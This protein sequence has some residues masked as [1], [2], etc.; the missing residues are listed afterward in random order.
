LP[1]VYPSPCLLCFVTPNK[2]D[3]SMLPSALPELIAFAVLGFLLLGFLLGPRIRLD[4]R[5]TWGSVPAVRN[6]KDLDDW[7]TTS[8]A[9]VPSLRAGTEARIEWTNP[10]QPGRTPIAFLYIHGFSASWQETAPVTSRLGQRF[11]ANVLQMRV[12]G[13]G[14]SPGDMLVDANEWLQ[15]VADAW[16]VAAQLGERIVIVATSNGAPLALWLKQQPGVAERLGALFFIAPNFRLRNPAGRMLTW[17]WA[18]V[19]AGWVAPKQI[20]WELNTDLERLV[21]TTGYSIKAVQQ[22][23]A[24]LDWVQRIRYD[25]EE[26]PLALMYVAADPTVHA[27]SAIAVFNQWGRA[28]HPPVS[29]ELIEIKTD[30]PEHVF[31]GDAKA[32]ERTDWVVDRLRH[33]LLAHVIAD[34]AQS[35]N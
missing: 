23:Q 13:H 24:L 12:A 7:L 33:F 3:A 8:E 32:P 29:K 21:W 22:C 15:S 30:A 9:R 6:L 35:E 27:E 11:G 34:D 31:V 1:L 5:V 10:Q 26:T 4:S 2:S 18:D 17:P 20:H 28:L 16:E 14:G 19:W 25:N